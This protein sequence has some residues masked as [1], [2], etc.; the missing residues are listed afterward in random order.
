MFSAVRAAGEQNVIHVCFSLIIFTMRQLLLVFSLTFLLLVG[1]SQQAH[2]CGEPYRI[3]ENCISAN[4][5]AEDTLC[6]ANYIVF[7]PII[8]VRA[9]VNKSAFCSSNDR[10]LLQDAVVEYMLLPYSMMFIFI[11]VS[12]MSYKR[13][14]KKHV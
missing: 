7:A 6:N 2:A 12:I 8:G 10:F 1:F 9:F 4:K 13:R 3:K 14:K 5:V 11:G